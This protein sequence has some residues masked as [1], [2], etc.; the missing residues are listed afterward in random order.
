MKMDHS[1]PQSHDDFHPLDYWVWF[2]LSL[3]FL[4]VPSQ[5]IQLPRGAGGVVRTY[6]GR[7][8]MERL[9]LGGWVGWEM[10]VFTSMTREREAGKKVMNTT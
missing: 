4:H 2:L 7:R 10:I 6:L 9:V 3:F 5:F 8:K 1:Q